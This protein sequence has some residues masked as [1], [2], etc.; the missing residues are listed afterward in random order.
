LP[1]NNDVLYVGQNSI[2]SSAEKGDLTW[3]PRL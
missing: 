3:S 2:V 1:Y